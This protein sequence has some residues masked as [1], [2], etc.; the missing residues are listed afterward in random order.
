MK[1][2]GIFKERTRVANNFYLELRDLGGEIILLA[3]DENGKELD[4]GWL[5]GINKGALELILYS[6]VSPIFGFKTDKQG[7]LAARKH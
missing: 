1:L 7:Y 4:S 5:L 2:I 6:S 3:V